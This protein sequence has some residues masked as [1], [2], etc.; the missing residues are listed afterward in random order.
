MK[1]RV[2]VNSASF[3]WNFYKVKCR[4]GMKFPNTSV[5]KKDKKQA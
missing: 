1:I 5:T 4:N 2:Q 3:I